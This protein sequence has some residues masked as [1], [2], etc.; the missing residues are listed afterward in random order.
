MEITFIVFFTEK[1]Q[2]HLPMRHHS[3]I[4]PPKTYPPPNAFLLPPPP[5]IWSEPPPTAGGAIAYF[6]DAFYETNVAGS[7]LASPPVAIRSGRAEKNVTGGKI[8]D[9]EVREENGRNGVVGINRQ[10]GCYREARA[11]A[12]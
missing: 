7:H 11:R 9:Q 4:S 6:L 10:G 12:R 3:S 2:Q 8:E 5:S 1:T